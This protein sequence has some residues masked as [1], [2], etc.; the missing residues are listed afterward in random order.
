MFRQK[1][2]IT[3]QGTKTNRPIS[4][5]LSLHMNFYLENNEQR[6]RKE[7]KNISYLCKEYLPMKIYEEYLL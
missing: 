5:S 7:G 4:L 3:D 6:E 1:D 2:T